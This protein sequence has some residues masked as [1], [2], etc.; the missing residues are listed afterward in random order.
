MY[1]IGLVVTYLWLNF[2]KYNRERELIFYF[3]QKFDFSLNVNDGTDFYGVKIICPFVAYIHFLLSIFFV[4][5]SYMSIPKRIAST[6][7][8]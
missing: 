1:E 3:L 6:C 2:P 5:V 4:D 7:E 8:Y